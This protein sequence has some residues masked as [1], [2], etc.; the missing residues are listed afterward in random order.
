MSN[1][2]ALIDKLRQTDESIAE[3]EAAF[4]QSKSPAIALSLQSL[5]RWRAELEVQFEQA[6]IT[7]QVDV[8]RY[9]IFD[10]INDSPAVRVVANTLRDFQELV[11]TAYEALRTGPKQRITTNAEA[12]SATS[13]NFAYTFSGSLGVVLTVPNDHLLMGSTYLDA[14]VEE[15]FGLLSASDSSAIRQKAETLGPAA[16]ALAYRWAKVQA[17]AGVGSDV[18]WRRGPLV[19]S[20]VLLQHQEL[21]HLEQ[22]IAQTTEIVEDRVPMRGRLVGIDAKTR[23]F[24]FEYAGDDIRGRVAESVSFETTVELPAIYDAVVLQRKRIELATGEESITYLL[25][26]LMPLSRDSAT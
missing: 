3:T 11:T 13:F 21:Q 4:A 5:Q 18:E 20:R 9:R 2:I 14:A 15:V 10:A 24:H 26:S 25:E 7:Q 8:C 1:L 6:T 16:V 17:E 12:R 19:R 22:L 23:T